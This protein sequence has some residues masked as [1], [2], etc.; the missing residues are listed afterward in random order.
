M[1]CRIKEKPTI[2]FTHH[3]KTMVINLKTNMMEV[4]LKE[5]INQILDP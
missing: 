1:W 5:I 2:P 3:N 4:S